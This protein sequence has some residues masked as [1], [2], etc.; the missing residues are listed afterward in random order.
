[1][2][3]QQRILYTAL[4]NGRAS[5]ILKLTAFVTIRLEHNSTTQLGAWPDVLE[6]ADHARNLS[7][8]AVFG[9]TVSAKAKRV[10]PDPDQTLWSAIFPST[11]PVRPFEFADFS[12]RAFRS[13]PVK[14]VAA[15]L[16][17]MYGLFAGESPTEHPPT[18]R[19]ASSA[20][21]LA[22]F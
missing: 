10:S 12:K 22:C 3:Q 7:F 6:W 5:N 1:M 14:D 17:D 4:P 11:T 20:A 8:N 15:Y 19:A 9:N 13:Y 21:R 18:M 2:A 16:K